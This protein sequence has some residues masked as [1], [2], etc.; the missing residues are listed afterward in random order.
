MRRSP[1]VV[2]EASSTPLA[3]SALIALT[4]LVTV[5]GCHRLF[6]LVE[7]SDADATID[8][9]GGVTSDAPADAANCFVADLSGGALDTSIWTSYADTT[10]SLSVVNGGV[11][12][13]VDGT[14]AS[15]YTGFSTRDPYS[16][17]G[18]W[19]EAELERDAPAEHAAAMRMELDIANA[20]SIYLDD[21]ISFTSRTTTGS[22]PRQIAYD[23]I[24]FRF[25][26]IR[27]DA[28]ANNGAGQIRFE[29]RPDTASQWAEQHRTNVL[30]PT[31]SLT[32][33][34]YFGGDQVA[35]RPGT[36]IFRAIQLCK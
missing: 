10:T 22:T 23:P 18:A 12:M 9:D 21:D 4:A 8:G 15:S 27:H 26:R 11:V 29:T 32:I 7:V 5:S 3:L 17:T 14:E 28:L 36:A 25:L 13:T 34:F 31:D 33:K 30:V 19:L 1:V 20:Y 6:G 2:R 35:P 24:A 16:F